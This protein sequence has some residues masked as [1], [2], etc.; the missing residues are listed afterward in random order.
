[1][2]PGVVSLTNMYGEKKELDQT[3]ISNNQIKVDLSQLPS[4]I[5]FIGI[6]FG[7]KAVER[8]I[9]VQK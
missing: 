9:V 7:Q 8:K 6:H 2:P 5:Y 1:M 3:I 4:G